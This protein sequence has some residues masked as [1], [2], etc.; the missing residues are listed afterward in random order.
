[1]SGPGSGAC[2][3][4]RPAAAGR[5]ARAACAQNQK[6]QRA[7]RAGVTLAGMKTAA[8]L[9]SLSS[10]AWAA[11]ALVPVPTLAS[12]P[13]EAPERYVRSPKL[14]ESSPLLRPYVISG[15]AAVSLRERDGERWLELAAHSAEDVRR[16]LRTRADPAS[17]VA[18][19]VD[20][21]ARVWL[22]CPTPGA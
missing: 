15:I 4:D 5:S 12:T 17:P 6:A 2:S 11:L 8:S 14:V 3:P 13:C 7:R 18:E 19:V 9:R 1:M 10:L 16:T 22:R 20:R 21:D